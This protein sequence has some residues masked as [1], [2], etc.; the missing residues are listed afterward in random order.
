MKSQQTIQYYNKHESKLK[1]HRRLYRVIH[2]NRKSTRFTF[3]RITPPRTHQM[4]FGFGILGKFQQS[5]SNDDFGMIYLCA[6]CYSERKKKSYPPKLKCRSTTSLHSIPFRFSPYS[7]GS[8]SL[9]NLSWIN[10][11]I[12]Q[13]KN[14]F[15]CW[16]QH[17][18]IQLCLLYFISFENWGWEW[19]GGTKQKTTKL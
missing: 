5:L 4:L 7:I 14:M 3:V 13:K 16:Q 19:D 12:R 11:R 9:F 1:W 2:G 15:L 8:T 6:V 17:W 18:M 10:C